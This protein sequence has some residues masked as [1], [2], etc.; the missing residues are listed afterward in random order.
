MEFPKI[1]KSSWFYKN[2]KSQRKRGAKICQ[3]CPFREG[4]EQQEL[5][6]KHK[7]ITKEEMDLRFRT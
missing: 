3:S 4:I 7:T 6:N 1:D 2:C 5:L